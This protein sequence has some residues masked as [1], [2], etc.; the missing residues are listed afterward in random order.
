MFAARAKCGR[1]AAR[2]E[3]FTLIE[4]MIVVAILGILAALAIP[5][6]IGYVRRSKTSEASELIDTIFKGDAS[7]YPLQHA[8]QGT[9]GT[10]ETYCTI[11]GGSA[12]GVPSANKRSANPNAAMTV[13]GFPDD[14]YVYYAYANIP[15]TMTGTPDSTCSHKANEA[16][17]YFIQATGDLDG[18]CP[19]G[20]TH[21]DPCLS[22]FELAVGTDADN[23]VYHARGIYI[24]NELE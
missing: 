12:G 24:D 19:V 17:L 5:A 14:A 22:F 10:T 3:G 7:Y 8:A 4:L 6:F 9:D 11:A 21:P 2:A 1:T 16:N 13:A 15:Y 20:V 23:V 18:D